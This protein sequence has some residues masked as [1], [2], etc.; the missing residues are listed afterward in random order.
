MW[1]KKRSPRWACGGVSRGLVDMEGGGKQGII[2]K[3]FLLCTDNTIATKPPSEKPSERDSEPFGR[4]QGAPAAPDHQSGVQMSDAGREEP[5]RSNA[6]KIS[7]K[8][9]PPPPSAT[10][11]E[12]EKIGRLF[13]APNGGPKCHTDWK[14]RYCIWLGGLYLGG[15]YTLGRGETSFWEL[16]Y[17]IIE[18][19]QLTFKN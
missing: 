3:R 14:G 6:R 15:V 10:N 7:P 17:C 19:L 11:T 5:H 4:R 8:K 9:M 18:T 13:F 1:G 2:Q 16:R 12:M